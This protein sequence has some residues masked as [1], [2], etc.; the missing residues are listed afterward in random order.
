V[1]V[2][3]ETLPNGRGSD[4]FRAATVRERLPAIGQTLTD[5]AH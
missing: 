3:Y 1:R 2:G 5:D 4:A